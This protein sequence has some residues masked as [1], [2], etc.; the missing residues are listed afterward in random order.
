LKRATSHSVAEPQTRRN[1]IEKKHEW[2]RDYHN[3]MISE[4][5]PGVHLEM[6]SF[7]HSADRLTRVPN[8]KDA[9]SAISIEKAEGT[10]GSGAG[11]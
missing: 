6:I 9:P 2:V 1:I 4:L 5:F 10:S 7:V 3:E 11:D 8:Q